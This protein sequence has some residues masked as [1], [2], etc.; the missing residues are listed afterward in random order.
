MEG[1]YIVYHENGQPYMVRNFMQNFQDGNSYTYSKTGRLISHAIY[2]RGRLKEMVF[3]DT[4]INID[5]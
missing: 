2:K 1:E 4:T 3:Q 5:D